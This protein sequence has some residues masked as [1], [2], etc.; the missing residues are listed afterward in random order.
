[1][2]A[3]LD[4]I[5]PL[6]E[7]IEELPHLAMNLAWSWNREAYRLFE[8]IDPTLWAMG[9][10][11][12]VRLL[13]DVDPERMEACA[14]NPA[15]LEL[16][17][18][19]LGSMKLLD[20]REGTWF[21]A[22]GVADTNHPVVYFCAEFAAHDSIPIYSGGLGI[23]AGDHLKSAS[24]LGIPFVGVGLLYSS[25]YFDQAF[26][27]DGW[28]IHRDEV[29]DPT[30]MPLS[31]LHDE[32]GPGLV[33]VE[34]EGRTVG[35]GAWEMMV[36]RTRVLLLDSNLPVNDQADRDLTA[37]LYGSG[38]EL[39]LK[40]EW[41]LGV[42]GVRL[43]E[44]LGVEPGCWHA[45]E[46]HATF[47]MIE[48]VRRFIDDGATLDDAIAR[49]RSKSLFTTHT[50]VPAGHD[51]FHRDQIERVLG[52]VWEKLGISEE[53]FLRIGRASETGPDTFHMTAGAIRMS[54]GVNGVSQLHGRVTREIW[55]DL[56]P[57]RD[58]EDVPI[59]AVTNGVHAWTWMSAP[60]QELLDAELG[61]WWAHRVEDPDTWDRVL[62]IEP[63]RVWAVHQ[64]MKRQ[65]LRFLI[66]KARRRWQREG[67]KA[68]HVVAAGP[69]L[70]PQALT[71]GFA[72]RFATYKRA[73]M[74]L[75][76]EERLMKLL[77]D[78]RRPV[79]IIFAGK[80]HPADDDGKRV[81]Q[82]IYQLSHDADAGGRVAFVQD[83]EMHIARALFNAVDL[84]L[85]VP[86]VPKEASGTSGMK[87]AM[88]FVPQLGTVDGWWAEG[89]TG[90]NGWSIPRPPEDVEDVDEW[91]WAR[92]FE[93]LEG[94]VVP[95]YHD[96]GDDGIPHAWVE[97]MKHAL[98]VSG[99]D[100]TTSR[101]VRDYA[102]RYYLPILG[103]GLGEDDPPVR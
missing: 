96:R 62:D 77:T 26:D 102:T 13:Q 25:G 38:E 54:Q 32:D 78:E 21:E 73:D 100:F 3:A 31:R 35:L 23:L 10:H 46:G 33:S 55:H 70:D 43:L 4:R 87:A 63:A 36:G 5:P 69:L 58:V 74:L 61:D 90:M 53:D 39:R 9:R 81:L 16:Y 17:E 56:W 29:V 45:N 42:G 57:D 1:M 92:M 49:V 98:W 103:D 84:W 44:A 101:M 67:G 60:V 7:P 72:R 41:I 75:R 47:M 18:A 50:P 2:N 83:Y 24:D 27:K 19:V 91:D 97:R 20:S 64:D 89:Y 14:A 93:I 88:N 65:S 68:R 6:P 51:N 79:Q 66:D 12:P 15:F 28:Q 22:Q 71:F 48:R 34:L 95:M 94:E 37:R 76:D 99:R 59:G 8:M 82:R 80:A 52:P 86:R 11:D 85:N 40:Q 30:R